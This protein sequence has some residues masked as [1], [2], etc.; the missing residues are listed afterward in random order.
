MLVTRLQGASALRLPLPL[1]P[2][3]RDLAYQQIPRQSRLGLDD[4]QG[5]SDLAVGY[6]RDV[7]NVPDRGACASCL[8]LSRPEPNTVWRRW[9]RDAA[10]RFCAPRA[11][12]D[13][14]GADGVFAV[15][16]CS[17]FEELAEPQ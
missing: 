12:D 9:L 5:A 7:G 1:Q 2:R 3:L 15:H 11:Y 13:K 10:I 16:K 8:A 17:E 6:A 14:R 4:L